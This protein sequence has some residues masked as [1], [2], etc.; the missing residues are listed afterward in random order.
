M[1]FVTL[2]SLAIVCGV[3]SFVDGEKVNHPHNEQLPQLLADSG[4]LLYVG[5]CLSLLV[6]V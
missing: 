4:V 5:L 3:D 6:E 1:T 2:L